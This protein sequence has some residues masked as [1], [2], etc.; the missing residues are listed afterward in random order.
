MR[1][2]KNQKVSSPPPLPTHFPFSTER[3]ASCLRY[4]VKYHYL[5][6]Y[7]AKKVSSSPRLPHSPTSYSL[8]EMQQHICD[9]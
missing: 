1:Q 2:Q 7:D 5:E 3:M 4:T 8:F 6:L 9:L